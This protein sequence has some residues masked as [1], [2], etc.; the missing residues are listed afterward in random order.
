MPLKK[1]KLIQSQDASESKAQFGFRRPP[2]PLYKSTAAPNNNAPKTPD[3]PT[4]LAAPV[5]DDDGA[6]L[7]FVLLLSSDD[8]DDDDVVEAAVVLAAL[9]IV[10]EA[11][12]ED[13]VPLP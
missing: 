12:P 10:D 11:T 3:T 13:A 6:T 8:D 5:G 4:L 9:E 2:R 7:A 1:C